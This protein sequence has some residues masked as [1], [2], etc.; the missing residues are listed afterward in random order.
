MIQHAAQP[1]KHLWSPPRYRDSLPAVYDTTL[2]SKI[3]F[4][5]VP[6]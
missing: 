4:I 6:I 5:D 3:L 2:D 1:M